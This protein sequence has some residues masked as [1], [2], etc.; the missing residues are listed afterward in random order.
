MP[1]NAGVVFGGG[2]E[3]NIC[4]YKRHTKLSTAQKEPHVEAGIL[5][6]IIQKYFP[7]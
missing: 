1:E 5:A 4:F 6:T 2:V 7:V 3:K